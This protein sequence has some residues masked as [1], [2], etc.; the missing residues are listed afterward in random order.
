MTK[1]DSNFDSCNESLDEN[2][3][4][5]VESLFELV[6][7]MEI[8]VQLTEFDPDQLEQDNLNDM[9]EEDVSLYDEEYESCLSSDA[10]ALSKWNHSVEGLNFV[11]WG[12]FNKVHV[13]TF[14]DADLSIVSTLI[15]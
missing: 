14:P 6:V 7:A 3:N 9:N 8:G 11:C 12:F 2:V 1:T 13:P 10:L 4:K 5:P 15:F